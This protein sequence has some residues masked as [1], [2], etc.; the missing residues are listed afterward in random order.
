MAHTGNTIQ[1]RKNKHLSPFEH[2]QIAAFKQ[3]GHSNRDIARRLG[4]AHQTI[5]NELKR[6]TTTQLKTGRPTRLISLK[7]N[8][9]YANITES[10]VV[11]KVS[12][13]SQSNLLILLAIKSSIMVGHLMR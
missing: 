6:G 13:L 9:L 12:C 11:L 2:G 5:A 3:A 8:R 4:R 7:R 1:N 10:I